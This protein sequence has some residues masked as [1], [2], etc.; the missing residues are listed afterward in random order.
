MS[1]V[2]HTATMPSSDAVLATVIAVGRARNSVGLSTLKIANVR[3][4]PPTAASSGRSKIARTLA[5]TVERPGA[6]ISMGAVLAIR[7]VPI[8]RKPQRIA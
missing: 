5:L 4:R 3:M 6:T 7:R 2:T 1:N 8:V